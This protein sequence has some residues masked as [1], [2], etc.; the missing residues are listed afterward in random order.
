MDTTGT[1]EMAKALA[2]HKC[3]TCI[4]KYYTVDEWKSFADANK[5]TLPF[6]AASSGTAEGDFERLCDILENVPEVK[7]ICLDVANG[8]SQ[9]FVEYVEKV[10]KAFPTHTIMAG[11]VVTGD[12]VEALIFAGADIVKV[13]IGPGSVCTTR[14]KTGVGYPQLSAVLECADN[15]H[16]LGAHIISVS[17]L[18]TEIKKNET[19][20]CIFQDGGCTCP[21][22]VAKAIGAGADFVMLG[23]ML[24]GHDQ[25]GGEVIEK[26]GKKRKLFYGMSSATAMKKHKGGVAEY[27]ASEG[28][29]VEVDYRGDVNVTMLD[30]LGG[31]RSACTYVGAG[32][33]KEMPK[34]TTFIR[35]NMQLNEVFS[36]SN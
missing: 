30:I 32:R 33:V 18:Q 6:I 7:F 20:S 15:A 10:R 25:A 34:R 5:E 2:A 35:V 16:G 26:D 9:F 19:F 17:L 3:H 31:L 36:S 1:F 28:K 27:R 23:G 29:T 4:H 14:K 13:G 11:N 8:Y 24:A 22:D 21:G 12:M